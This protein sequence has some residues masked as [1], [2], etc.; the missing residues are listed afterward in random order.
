MWLLSTVWLLA[1][2]S[3]MATPPQPGVQDQTSW[4]RSRFQRAEE[5]G[6][7]QS[8][9]VS[10]VLEQRLGS[11]E[12][13][14]ELLHCGVEASVASLPARLLAERLRAEIAVSE[15]MSGF[16]ASR[17]QAFEPS[18]S[19]HEGKRGLP[20]FESQW[21]V[22]VR[23]NYT[24]NSSF[25][26]PIMDDVE[27]KLYGLRHFKTR[28]APESELEARER[29]PY[30]AVNLY[31][32]DAGS[33]LY[34]DVSVVMSTRLGMDTVLASAV[35]TGGWTGMCNRTERS[36]AVAASASMWGFGVNCSAYG[37]KRTGLS[38]LRHVD[39][40]LL[41]NDGYWQNKTL[42]RLMCRVLSPWGK[43]PLVGADLIHYWEAMPLARLPYPSAIKFVIGSFPGLFGTKSGQELQSWCQERGW[44]LMWS[45]GFN[46]EEYDMS[47]LQF[48][49]A[50]SWT[51][52]LA[53]DQ[54]L[55]DPVVLANSTAG[56]N[57]SAAITGASTSVFTEAWRRV[58]DL[59]LQTAR[60]NISVSNS[61]WALEWMKLTDSLSIELSLEPLRAGACSD[62]DAC[63]GTTPTGHCIC[64]GA[65][66]DAMVIGTSDASSA[67]FI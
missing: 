18:M 60:Q 23:N 1:T 42:Q 11:S 61:S 50:P 14:Q 46:L 43:F 34:G 16:T 28:G 17:F 36:S 53:F 29:S 40:L 62:T 59:R 3:C 15:V 49:S 38:T 12:M 9:A 55:A 66:Q 63:V 41:Q 25:W 35:D 2:V 39:H 48:W 5:D 20:Q 10:S 31:K 6:M 27:T 21:E 7:S 26:W 52:P 58:Q 65:K 33:L 24:W 56:S 30:F 32:V 8:T 22:G 45:L 13:R 19:V 64:Y 51:Q 67:V 4:Q 47:R 44:V 37:D 54:R 57:M